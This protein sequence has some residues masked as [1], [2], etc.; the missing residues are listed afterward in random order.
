MSSKKGGG[1]VG[2]QANKKAERYPMRNKKN[3]SQGTLALGPDTSEVEQIASKHAQIHAGLDEAINNKGIKL[4]DGETI[5]PAKY[6]NVS[7][8][9]RDIQ[10]RIMAA[11]LL[12]KAS[13]AGS[14]GVQVSLSPDDSML[15]IMRQKDEVLAWMNFERYLERKYIKSGDLDKREWLRRNYPPYFEMREKLIDVQVDLDRRLARLKLNGPQDMS[16]EYLNF[17]IETGQVRPP[18]EPAWKTNLTKDQQ[19]ESYQR[20][21]FNPRRT[22]DPAKKWGEGLTFNDKDNYGPWTASGFKRGNTLLWNNDTAST[23]R[24][25]VSDSWLGTFATNWGIPNLQSFKEFNLGA[26]DQRFSK[27]YTPTN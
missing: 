3:L 2:K 19:K 12:G 24:D 21:L 20:G 6:F 18:T 25:E 9:E 14:D 10:D 5:F 1:L 13:G 27:I 7:E 15:S 11:R 4:S 26:K 8:A 17:L 16:D 22:L 23:A